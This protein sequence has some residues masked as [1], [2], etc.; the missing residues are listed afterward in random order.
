MSRRIILRAAFAVAATSFLIP[1]VGRGQDG[2]WIGVATGSWGNA[3]NWQGGTIANGAGSTAT[4]GNGIASPV[5]VT[6]DINRT[7]GNLTFDNVVNVTNPP[8]WT[9]GG[10]T[11]LTLSAADPQIN[12]FLPN[13]TANLSTQLAG[14]QG[15][16]KVGPG[17]LNL[18]NTNNMTGGIR[19]NEGTLAVTRTAA[20]NPLGT[21]AITLN[22]GTL[23]LGAVASAP[24]ATT[25]G[26]NQD[27]IRSV[28]DPSATPWGVTAPVDAADYVYYEN[29]IPGAPATGGLPGGDRTFVSAQ[30]PLVT[31]QLQPY[32]DS[33]ANNNNSIRLAATGNN[34]T[35]S[36]VAPQQFQSLSVLHSTGSGTTRYTAT[37]TFTDNTTSVYGGATGF[38]SNDWFG[39]TPFA[40]SSLNR[41][42]I[43][44]GTFE[45]AGTNPRLYATDIALSAADRAKTVQSITITKVSGGGFLNVFGFSGSGGTPI[46]Q[47]F[48]ANNLNVTADSTIDLQSPDAAATLGTLSIGANTL[49]VVSN[50]GGTVTAGATTLS[51]NPTF[52]A[53]AGA[54]LALGAVND[55]GTARTITKTGAGTLTLNAPAASAGT[56]T[57]LV[58]N[59]GTANLNAAGALGTQADVTVAAGAT[60]GI[61]AA[62]TVASVGG[63]GGINLGNAL[64]IS[65]PTATT[66]GG[67]IA[68]IG[69]L[70][71]TGGTTTLDSSNTFSGGTI[72]NPSSSL[73]ATT[74]GAL[75][76]GPV[77]VNGGTLVVGGSRS[78]VTGFGAVGT[79]ST[80]NGA[81]NVAADVLTL[82]PAAG[83][84][85]GSLFFNN[86][87][88]T[89]AFTA[90]FTYNASAGSGNPADGVT[91]TFQNDPRGATALGDGGGALGYGGGAA[92]TPSASLQ[93]NIYAPAGGGRGVTFAAN[94]ATGG[95]YTLTAPLELYNTTVTVNVTYDGT[96]ATA[97]FNDGT[98][99]FTLGPV[100]ID[101]GAL[102]G[103]QAFVGFTGGTGGEFA[104]Q[105][106]SNFSYQTP[107]FN[108]YS[109]TVNLSG[110]LTST[111]NV[112]A[113]T[114][115]PTVTMGPLGFGSNAN[116]VVGA[117]AA[118]P[119]NQ[120]FGL[121]FGATT[122]NGAHTV[123]VANN[124]T[125]SG[126]V[127]FGA[128]GGTGSLTKEGAGTLI[129][130]AGGTYTGPTT[131]NAGT[132]LLTNTTGSAT[133]TGNV[134]VSAGT[135]GGT[136]TASGAVTIAQG[137]SITPGLSIGT[138]TTGNL[139]LNGRYLAEVSNAPNAADRINVTGS[140]TL[141][142][143]SVL[144]LPAANTY[145]PASANTVYTLATYS[146]T[147][148]GQFGTTIGVP[149]GYFIQYGTVIVGAITLSPVPEPAHILLI[150]A[151][152][153][154]LL[155]WRRGKKN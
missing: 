128:V 152:V 24:F 114:A 20:I 4:F 49:S 124:G 65:G 89:D 104:A 21:N 67:R 10:S 40:L 59:G 58:I 101:L 127:L 17:T 154:G 91:F 123:S 22:G 39:G 109:N 78:S 139:T 140:V 136:G 134:L 56:G 2:S 72:I 82:T 69:S 43:T 118:T 117:D 62:Q 14:G 73:V 129:L 79:D 26:Y 37:L 51:A 148:S 46:S 125:G 146:G 33:T 97:T 80:V 92:I 84:Q 74:A 90:S 150:A 149:S 3:A 119:A 155:R 44:N 144:E 54:G 41:F 31:Y 36:L 145:D 47:N 138:L 5:T 61:G 107:T 131:V 143:T 13:L 25:G 142:S 81:A 106:I 6:L 105:T 27:V 95:P 12:V 45:N 32:G 50:I 68:G 35:V 133:G 96:N 120:S 110:G 28:A 147:L 108:T 100:P 7:L 16:T 57:Q 70:T 29:G 132:L 111:V 115:V 1:S 23:R 19:L 76:T 63:N 112:R 30:N 71:R 34:G 83:G 55:G 60:L 98:N 18:T 121:N 38:L 99:N 88:R 15:F 64:T 94:G 126:T 130:S 11:T 87:V 75:G 141:G 122:L 135:L 153:G 86:R 52:N 113:S 137:A 103:S 42:N 66:I 53:G 93:L 116:L 102:V 9:I 48:S 8:A 77:V 151:G 85:A